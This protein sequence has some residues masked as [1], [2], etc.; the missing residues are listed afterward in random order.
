M[1]AND[2][3]DG[4]PWQDQR[5]ASAKEAF[6]H[7][8]AANGLKEEDLARPEK[9]TS[10]EMVLDDYCCMETLENFPKLKSVVLIQQAIQ[11]LEG[12]TTCI[13]LERLLLNENLIE[14]VEGLQNCAKLKKLYLSTNNIKDIGNGLEGLR[15]LEVLWIAGN[16]LTC[17][18]GLQ[19]APNLLE[20][21]AA[22]NQLTTIIGC[23]DQNLKLRSINLAGNRI[24]SFKE[25][26]DVARLRHLEQMNFSD[27]DWGENPIC[28]LC[29]YQTYT[30]YHLSTLQ[31]HDCMNVGPEEH[32]AS[33]AAFSKK[34]LYYNMRIKMLK[35]QAA[36]AIRSAKTLDEERR[37]SIGR[38]LAAADNTLRR[39]NAFQ[40]ARRDNAP[41]ARPPQAEDPA[42]SQDRQ[43]LVRRLQL[44]Q[45]ELEDTNA[46]WNSFSTAVHGER[47]AQ[48]RALLLELQTGGNVRFEQGTPETDPWAA[49]IEDLVKGRFRAEEFSRFGILDLKVQSVTR[50][51]H[52]SLRIRF[53]E[54]LERLDDNG[55]KQVD[56]LFYVPDPRRAEEDLQ[57]VAEEGLGEASPSSSSRP[58]RIILTNSVSIAEVARLDH[59]AKTE[60]GQASSR[61]V[62]RIARLQRERQTVAAG[63]SVATV[64]LLEDQ[65]SSSLVLPPVCSGVLMIC[66]VFMAEQQS[67]NPPCFDGV[68]GDARELWANEPS[69]LPPAGPDLPGGDRHPRVLYRTRESDPKQKVWSVPWPELVLP[70]FLVEFDY[71]QMSEASHMQVKPRQAELGAS[72]GRLL[73]DFAFFAKLGVEEQSS[74]TSANREED[75]PIGQDSVLQHWPQ[76]LPELPT[77]ERFEPSMWCQPLLMLLAVPQPESFSG[78]R[79]LNLHGRKLRRIEASTLQLLTGLET[80][81]LSF[82]SIESMGVIPQCQTLTTLDVSHN[83]MQKVSSMVGFPS[84]LRL[85][86]SWNLLLS[87][88]PLSILQRDVPQLEH[89]VILGNTATRGDNGRLMAIA[90]LSCLRT[91]DD[92]KVTPEE[93]EKGK[94][95]NSEHP[96]ITEALLMQRSFVAPSKA[97]VGGSTEARRPPLPGSLGYDP[98]KDRVCALLGQG[99]GGSSPSRMS[100]AN[101]RSQVEVVDLRGLD[102]TDLSGLSNF[103]RC[104]SLRLCDN[105]L[106]G[107]DGLRGCPR[108][109]ELSVE[110]NCL[111]NLSGLSHLQDLR[112]LDAGCNQITDVLDLQKLDKLCQLSLED[113]FVDS[114]DTFAQLYG[115]MELYLSNNV[116]EELRSILLL[117][118]LPK[119]IILDLSGNDLCSAP[120]YRLYTIFHLRKLKVLDGLPVTQAEQQEADHKFSGRV[121]MELLEDKLGPSP[122]CY[123]FRTVDLS[124]Q[125][126]RELGQLLNDDI[127]PSLRELILD[128]NPFSDIRNVG[129][130]SKLLV[131]RM[132]KT[133]IDLEKGMLGDGDA[134]GGIGTFPQLQVLEMGQS[135]I[136]D[137][138]Y[139]SQFPLQSL[140]ILHLPGNDITKIEGL[141][142]LEQLREL[143]ID[144]NKVK[145]LPA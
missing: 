102:L 123:T 137:I 12:L 135:G 85:D 8:C 100:T 97:S 36:D 24:C 14:K 83:L 74:R 81:I 130:L 63:G 80:L 110:R 42:E 15:S 56:H 44:N 121:T 93:V 103:P 140:R 34:R 40:L 26:L 54:L 116:V 20:V 86:L 131:L 84:L 67:D 119:L 3:G 125:G 124:G 107:L 28:F 62:R 48:I 66:S 61:A 47:D 145:Q 82:N 113:N 71:Q 21:N 120:D 6:L 141:S 60:M 9:V 132:N 117:K 59:Y 69:T 41:E 13:E 18:Q 92:Q 129:P 115:L 126:I 138:S 11:K 134:C 77:I 49:Q 105:Q 53:E 37:A 64:D 30:L 106:T 73:R 127:F 31:V 142:N 43:A 78:L 52:R 95:S 1:S 65:A 144:K 57:S 70:E 32:R 50:L 22:S 122:S 19:N 90:K 2:P 45:V 75:V 27:P 72:I 101:W 23:F 29:N 33:E 114:L 89:L 7:L 79:V 68:A 143:V 111:S 35:R 104:Q 16:Q 5:S 39:A 17:L 128:G 51:H 38:D 58:P 4:A 25:V 94:A 118:Q 139:F 133:R 87:L 112:R 10:I 108:L 98:E 91:F 109:E 76:A 55:Q 46:A 88:E 136:T 99:G 96:Q